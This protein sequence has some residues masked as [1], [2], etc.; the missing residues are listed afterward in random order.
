MTWLTPMAVR[1]HLPSSRDHLCYNVTTMVKVSVRE[2]KAHLSELIRRLERGESITVTKRGKP[3]G[4][5]SPIPDNETEEQRLQRKLKD[6]VARGIITRIPKGKPKGLPE[7][8]KLIGE[9]PSMSEMI[10]E[11]R[12]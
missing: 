9:G 6:L 8:V 10:L 3:V 11:D 12:R 2:M 1:S 5:L 4:V 7:P